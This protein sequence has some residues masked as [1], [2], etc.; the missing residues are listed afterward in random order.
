MV[1]QMLERFIR[2]FV[3]PIEDVDDY[4]GLPIYEKIQLLYLDYLIEV[5]KNQCLNI[6]D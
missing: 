3:V 2:I 4:E 1:M 5:N 6:N